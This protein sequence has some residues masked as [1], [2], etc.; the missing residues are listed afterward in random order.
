[1]AT[2][3]AGYEVVA[4]YYVEAADVPNRVVTTWFPDADC[5]KDVRALANSSS[6]WVTKVWASAKEADVVLWVCGFPCRELTIAKRNR[7]GLDA[8]ETAVFR[9]CVEL[10]RALRFGQ[11]DGTPMLRCIWENVTSMPIEMRDK[12][13]SM[14]REVDNCIEPLGIDARTTHWANRPRTWW[15]TSR[16]RSWAHRGSWQ[17]C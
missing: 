12:I 17:R 10:Y 3:R 14:L 1:M 5:Q 16:C 15:T 8:G 2:L 4:H 11:P 13:T 9:D 6:S 7:R